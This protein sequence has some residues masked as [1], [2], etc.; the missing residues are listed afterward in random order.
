MVRRVFHVDLDEFIAAVEVLRHPELEGRP[1]VVGG[2]G[3]PT[4]R[5]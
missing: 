2:D 3:D 1:V 4:K 5:G